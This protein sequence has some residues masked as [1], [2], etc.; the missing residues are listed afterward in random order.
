[1]GLNAERFALSLQIRYTVNDAPFFFDRLN[2]SASHMTPTSI[3][4]FKFR[5]CVHGFECVLA[6]D[7][8]RER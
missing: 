2:S 5:F 4:K 1:M 7:A 8:W 6:L 3:E